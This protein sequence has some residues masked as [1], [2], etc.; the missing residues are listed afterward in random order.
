MTKEQRAKYQRSLDKMSAEQQAEFI[1]A[2]EILNRSASA[3]KITIKGQAYYVFIFEDPE[4]D[5]V[6][7]MKLVVGAK[8]W[9][10]SPLEMPLKECLP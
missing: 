8:G 5:S 1:H 4:G 10:F 7:K 2:V 9:T 6:M 3:R